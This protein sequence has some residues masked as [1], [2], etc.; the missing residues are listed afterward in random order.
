MISVVLPIYNEE[1]GLSSFIDDLYIQMKSIGQSFEII[2]VN[3]GS[4][5]KSLQL[6]QSL[7]TNYAE[8]KFIGLS[9]NFGHQIAI[10]AGI[11]YASG[12]QVIL[13]DSDGQD[14]PEVIPDLIHK[15]D[16]GYDVVY[17]KR[18]K[19][20]KESVMKKWTASLFYKILNKIT[21]IEIPVDTGDFRIINRKVIDALKQMPEKQRYLRGQIAWLGFKQTPVEYERKGRNAGE[22]N[23]TYK[24]MIGLAFDAITSFSNWPL[25]LATLSG[26]VCAVIGFILILY[27]LYA[28]FIL[29]IYEPGWPSLMISIVFLGG[30]QLLGIGMIGEY[31]ARINDNVKGRPLYLVD[32]TNIDIHA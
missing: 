8:L 18:I 25:R 2:L 26:F 15:M 5:D 12:D 23:Y 21:S 28:K 14:P 16:E 31:I 19:R 32:D 27:T 24:K 17:A 22:T 30:I 10:S 29:K 3:D 20:A 9:R 4:T 1:K 6:I 7:C 11:D 13:M